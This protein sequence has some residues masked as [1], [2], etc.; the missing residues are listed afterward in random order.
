MTRPIQLF[1]KPPMMPFVC[2]KCGAQKREHFV[3]LGIDSELR[4]ND[5]HGQ[6]HYTEGVIYFCSRCMVSLLRDYT[7]ALFDFLL[8]QEESKKMDWDGS[9][10]E[11]MTL[12][13]EIYSLHKILA[14]K[15]EEIVKRDATIADMPKIAPVGSA[16]K[17]IEDLLGE[18]VSGPGTGRNVPDGEES[19][20]DSTGNDSESVDDDLQ[21]E[22][23]A[24]PEIISIKRDIFA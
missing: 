15:D 23:S 16:T 4:R 6:T 3:D 20:D 13:N 9:K 11:I 14:L 8:N 22:S 7:G 10:N 18:E 17:V 5:E 2:A 21:S 24:E 19:G 12:Q 1:D